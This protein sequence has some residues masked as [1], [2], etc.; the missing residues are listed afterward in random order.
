ML[1]PRYFSVFLAYLSLPV[2]RLARPESSRMAF[3]SLVPGWSIS[4]FLTQSVTGSVVLTARPVRAALFHV[5]RLRPLALSM[6]NFAMLMSPAQ[7]ATCLSFSDARPNLPLL[8]SVPLCAPMP[9]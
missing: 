3:V 6:L 8:S 5:M 9:A 2:N 1:P 7:L 4:A